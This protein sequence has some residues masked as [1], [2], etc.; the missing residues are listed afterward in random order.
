[1]SESYEAEILAQSQQTGGNDRGPNQS[2]V[3]RYDL[4]EEDIS[5]PQ[6]Q[7]GNSKKDEFLF[8]KESE[9]LSKSDHVKNYIQTFTS[10]PIIWWPFSDPR[11]PLEQGRTRMTWQCVRHMV[12]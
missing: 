11:R 9:P 7:R 12:I 1:M 10:M 6:L 4:Q 5:S 2:E 8:I 3:L